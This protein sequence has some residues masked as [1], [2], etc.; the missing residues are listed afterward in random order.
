MK[1]CDERLFNTGTTSKIRKFVSLMEDLRS[2][3]REYTLLDFYQ[4][5][6][7][8]RGIWR[9]S[10]WKSPSKPRPHRK[11]RRT[12][13]CDDPIYEERDEATL[14]NFLE[15]MALVSDIDSLD[16][17]QN[18]V[19]LM[20]MHVSKGLEYPMFLSSVL[21]KIFSPVADPLTRKMSHLWRRSAV[22]PMSE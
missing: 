15:E 21:R 5:A 17:E 2:S 4:V 19:T 18:S 11:L 16:E 13:Q 14:Q 22:L 10:K 3:A 7:E 20:T 6:L 1:A 12:F 8:R 9:C